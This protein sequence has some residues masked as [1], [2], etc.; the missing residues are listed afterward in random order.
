M[1]GISIDGK[2]INAAES[3]IGQLVTVYQAICD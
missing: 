2:E 1:G 3:G